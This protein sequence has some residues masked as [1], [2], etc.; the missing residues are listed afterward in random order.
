MNI[1]IRIYLKKKVN[2]FYK[3]LIIKI[4]KYNLYTMLMIIIK[5]TSK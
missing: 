2:I 5:N 3:L 1:F 4:L